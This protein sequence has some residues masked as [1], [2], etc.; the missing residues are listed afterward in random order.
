MIYVQITGN[1]VY[2]IGKLQEVEVDQHDRPH[3]PHKIKSTHVSKGHTNLPSYWRPYFCILLLRAVTP[4]C[5]NLE[6]CYSAKPTKIK[7]TWYYI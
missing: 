1:T 4:I 5:E 2:N 7:L 6:V 3:H